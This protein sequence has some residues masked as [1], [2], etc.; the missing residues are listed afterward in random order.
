MNG[1]LENLIIRDMEPYD[2]EAVSR[3]EEAAFS[4]PWSR[5]DFLEMIEKP[6]AA[7][8]VAELDGEVVGGCGLLLI[9]GEGNITNVV[10]AENHRNCGIGEA[11]MKHLL[12][13]GKQRGLHAFTLEVRISN[14]V[15]IHLYEKLG[16]ESAGV[17]PHFYEKPTEDALIMW[18]T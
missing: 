4:M 6:D 17:R 3:L 14:T 10:V 8:Y 9:A 12:A 2:A 15:A 5:Q 1:R 13:D 11:L 7:Y 18:R 16:F